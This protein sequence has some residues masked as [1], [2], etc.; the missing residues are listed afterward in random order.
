MAS[1]SRR[2]DGRV[3]LRPRGGPVLLPRDEHPP[4][5]RAPGDRAR[6]GWTSSSCSCGG[7]GAGPRRRSTTAPGGHAI[8]VRLYAEDATYTPQ[9]AR[10]SPS[11]CR[12]RRVRTAGRIGRRVDSGFAS[13]DEVSTLYDAMLA[14]V[15]AWAPTREQ[16]IRTLVAALRRARIHGSRPTVTSSSDPHRPGVRRRRGDDDAGWSASRNGRARSRSDLGDRRRADAGRGRRG[17]ANGP[18]GRPGGLAQRRRQPQRT[19]FEGHEPVEW[20]GT[21][22]GFVVDGRHRARGRRRPTRDSRSTASP[23][24]HADRSPSAP[25]APRV[26]CGSTAHMVR[27][28]ARGPALHRPGRRGGERS[29]L[30]PMPGTVVKVSSR[31]A[32][33]SRRATPCW[34]WRP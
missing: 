17:P 30:A 4:P 27:V 11:T 1:V 21:R 2:R 26:S 10:S 12:R 9:A 25:L 20:W 5:G 32:R 13:G 3:P 34:S 8:E 31:P 6:A 18:A 7:R 33:R 15:I 23:R 16:A 19:I 29:L 14:K 24:R 22:D 28:S